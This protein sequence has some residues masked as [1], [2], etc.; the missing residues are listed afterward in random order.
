MTLR[1]KRYGSRLYNYHLAISHCFISLFLKCLHPSLPTHL[2]PV[3]HQFDNNYLMDSL[4]IYT[5]NHTAES[6][7]GSLTKR[8]QGG[9]WCHISGLETPTIRGSSLVLQV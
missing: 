9:T 8:T 6:I 7:V 3:Q 4:Q 1:W 2:E 5:Y